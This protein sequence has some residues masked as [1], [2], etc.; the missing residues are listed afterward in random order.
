[1]PLESF[2]PE[3]WTAEGPV[4]SFLGFP[5]PTRM[6]V[7]RLADRNLFLWSPI[8]LSDAL[9]TEVAA[10]GEVAHLVA[11][12]KL[13][14]LWLGAWQAAYPQARLYAPPGLRRKRRDL[15]FDADLGD[16]PEPGWAHDIDQV[17]VTGNILLTEIV[18]LH[19]LSRTA[20][21]AD[22]LQ[23]FRPGWFKGWRGLLARLDGIVSP[24]HGAP[25]ELRA[26]FWQRDQARA[27]LRRVLKFAPERVLIAHGEMARHN[28]ARFVRKGFR[29][30]AVD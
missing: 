12:N 8:P 29:W 4:V 22:L 21:F 24:N 1:M 11:P 15:A 18:F 23:N 13:H 17:A 14:H 16:A 7:I 26:G 25:R 10:L 6:A 27:A 19:R 28:G 5:Y 30:L 2:G 3:I 9:R 20:L